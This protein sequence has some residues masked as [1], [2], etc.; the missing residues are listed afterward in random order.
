[1][2]TVLDTKYKSILT[3]EQ[4]LARAVAISVV[5]AKPI[6][7]W[8]VTIPIIFILSYM[9]RKSS[10]EI[11]TQNFLFTKNLAMEAA[12]EIIKKGQPREEVMSRI[13]DKT[14]S[15]L[16]SVKEGIYS[17]EIRQMQLKEIGLLIDHYCKLLKAEGKDCASLVINAYKS[18]KDY[19]TFLRQLKEAEKQVTHAARQ[20]LGAQ[21]DPEIVFRME[22]ATDRVRT[23][24]AGKI[25]G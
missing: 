5:K 9:R 19:S 25:F 21:T 14:S 10:R 4:S 1:M 2:P 18:Q 17:E 20:T 23:A 11:F 8:E 3:R 22:E 12:L 7:V 6:T 16:T 24:E 13:E 15:L